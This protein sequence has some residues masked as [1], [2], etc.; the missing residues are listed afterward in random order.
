[1][2]KIR[3]KG[4]PSKYETSVKNRFNEITEWLETGATEK[5]VAAN[6][7]IHID[8]WIEYKKKYSELTDLIKNSRKNPVIQ[9]KKAMLKRAVGFQYEEKKVT[10]QYIEFDDGSGIKT[11]AK[12][13][14]TEVTTKTALPDPAAGLILLQHWDLD[15]KGNT[16][17]S[18]DPANRELKKEELELK[19]KQAEEN[20]W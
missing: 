20:D 17:W 16:K 11:P 4:R 9:I 15:E 12:V 1:M 19:K 18:R 13:V 2:T 3:S 7:G 14:K 8:T 10:T 6:L 5:E